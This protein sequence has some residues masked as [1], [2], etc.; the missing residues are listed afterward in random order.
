MPI[1]GIM[2]SNL[3]VL[4]IFIAQKNKDACTNINTI[5]VMA[6]VISASEISSKVVDKIIR[7]NAM[8]IVARTGVWVDLFTLLKTETINF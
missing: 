3:R 5:N 8:V 6:L 4:E 1:E 2:K 7:N